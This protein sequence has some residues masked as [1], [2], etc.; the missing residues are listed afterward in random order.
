MKRMHVVGLLV[1]GAMLL[2]ACQAA[3]AAN[4]PPAAVVGDA[5]AGTG[6]SDDAQKT[7]ALA[8]TAQVWVDPDDQA[9]EAGDTLTVTVRVQDA[10]DLAGYEIHIAFDPLLLDGVDAE[11][12]GFLGTSGR[13]VSPMIPQIDNDQ[14]VLAFAAFSLS[15][16]E[17]GV[18]GDGPLALITFEAGPWG[19]VSALD[20]EVQLYDSDGVEYDD[21]GVEDGSVTVE[22]PEL[23]QIFLPLVLRTYGP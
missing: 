15:T 16:T 14:G 6:R 19:G 23:S 4:G 17:P 9:V 3:S 7:A 13:T 5:P 1:L 8:A 11:D 18:D 10:Q 21:V 2:V 22:G 12:A 20:L